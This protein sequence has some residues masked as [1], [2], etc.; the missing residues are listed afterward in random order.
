MSVIQLA[1]TLILDSQTE[2]GEAIEAIADLEP[3]K[4][5]RLDILSRLIDRKLS[6]IALNE[7][8]YPNEQEVSHKITVNAS[9]T[10]SLNIKKNWLT[11]FLPTRLIRWAS[12]TI[13]NG[14]GFSNEQ[15]NQ[16]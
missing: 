11:K 2:G 9:C 10:N 5:P 12:C 3:G 4:S 14:I 16:G 1:T 15:N 6:S 13:T 8:L 7:L